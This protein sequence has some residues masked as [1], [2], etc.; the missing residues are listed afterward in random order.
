MKRKW[1]ELGTDV[2]GIEELGAACPQTPRKGQSP[3]T[4]IVL[5]F[6]GS[7]DHGF[8]LPS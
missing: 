5:D 2:D 8:L 6:M 1:T 4:H 3:F 7:E